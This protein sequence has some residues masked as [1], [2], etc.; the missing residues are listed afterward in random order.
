MGVNDKAEA[1]YH[2]HVD[3]RSAVTGQYVD[4]E[5]A[6][7]NPDTTVAETTEVKVEL[8]LEPSIQKQ[9]LHEIREAVAADVSS[10][11]ISLS[12]VIIENGILALEDYIDAFN[13][14]SERAFKYL[15]KQAN[16]K[17]D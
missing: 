8:P 4:A 11:I 3:H 12:G 5:E 16:G 1:T 14:G 7:A 10:L 13:L 2:P 6:A 15:R 17:T 9:E